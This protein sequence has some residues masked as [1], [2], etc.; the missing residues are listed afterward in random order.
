MIDIMF[1]KIIVYFTLIYDSKLW[2]DQFNESHGTVILGIDCMKIMALKFNNLINHWMSFC[3]VYS[4]VC[5]LSI[6]SPSC[7]FCHSSNRMAL[8]TP[9][10]L[11][12]WWSFLLKCSG[13]SPAEVGVFGSWDDDS[14][15]VACAPILFSMSDRYWVMTSD[16]LLFRFLSLNMI[17]LEASLNIISVS[18]VLGLK[19][20]SVDSFNTACVAWTRSSSCC[21]RQCRDILEMDRSRSGLVDRTNIDFLCFFCVS[22]LLTTRSGR[23]GRFFGLHTWWW[24]SSSKIIFSMEA[25]TLSSLVL[26]VSL[27]LSDLSREQLTF[28]RWSVSSGGIACRESN[29]ASSPSCLCPCLLFSIFIFSSSSSSCDGVGRGL[30]FSSTVS[31]KRATAMPISCGQSM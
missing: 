20:S 14:W 26:L 15:D 10:V 28:W 19:I 2:C 24:S 31:W 22:L 23:C 27:K 30:Q 11:H 13:G 25:V 17:R 6:M 29:S 21:C 12:R 3:D 1:I 16:S 4:L 9:W 18:L 5:E 8:S 7:N